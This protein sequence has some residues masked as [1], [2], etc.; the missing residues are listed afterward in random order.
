MSDLISSQAKTAYGSILVD[1]FDTWKRPHEFTIYKTPRETVVLID[2]DYSKNWQSAAYGN[3][4][5]I[6]TEEK[7]SFQVRMWFPNFPQ[8]F[9]TYQPDDKNVRVKMSQD[10]GIIK[11]QCEKD[12]YEYLLGSEKVVIFDT[13]YNLHEDI[14]RL[15]LFEMNLFSFTL[16]KQN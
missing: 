7:R 4:E 9:L 13:I 14:R 2:P 11:I 3:N 5:I 12:C 1:L 15:G 10:A 6:Y 8:Q 16:M